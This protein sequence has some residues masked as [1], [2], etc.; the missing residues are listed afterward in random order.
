MANLINKSV[1]IYC[2]QLPNYTEGVI[3]KQPRGK[4]HLHISSGKLKLKFQFLG[5]WLIDN[6]EAFSEG[7]SCNGFLFT[8]KNGILD[9]RIKLKDFVK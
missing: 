7:K 2:E 3:T 8:S 1:N 6:E 4:Y 9:A 5:G